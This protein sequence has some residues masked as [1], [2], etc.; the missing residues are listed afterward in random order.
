MDFARV[1]HTLSKLSQC[2]ITVKKKP[3]IPGFPNIVNSVNTRT[4]ASTNYGTDPEQPEEEI[5]RY[6][7]FY[8]VLC[9]LFV[10]KY[11]SYILSRTLADQVDE[12]QYKDFYYQHH[13][14]AVSYGHQGRG[15]GSQQYYMT[16]D[17]VL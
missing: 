9:R 6:C 2:S 3:N 15:Q 12:D 10:Y 1:L 14:G 8:S 11:V 17:Q 13:G 5:Y 16:I 4:L 7:F